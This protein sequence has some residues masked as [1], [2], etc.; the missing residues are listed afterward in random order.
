M[1]GGAESRLQ[2][3]VLDIESEVAHWNLAARLVASVERHRFERPPIKT[4][5]SLGI[6]CIQ[7]H[8]DT[9][10]F[11]PRTGGQQVRP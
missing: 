5:D 3:V 2:S 6:D 7:C 8:Q 9:E 10:A 11:L 1:L 4:S